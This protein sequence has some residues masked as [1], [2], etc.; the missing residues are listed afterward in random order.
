MNKLFEM[1]EIGTS[2]KSNEWYTPPYILEAVRNV[3]GPIKLDPAS[4]ELA[5][6]TV[7]AE[8]YFTKDDNGLTRPWIA[9]SVYL[10]PPYGKTEQGDGSNLRYFTQHLIE[11]YERGNVK[12]AILLIPVNTATSWFPALFAYSICFP[13]FRI[14][15]IKANGK[16]SNGVSFGTCFVY[17]G[18][19]VLKFA[20][21]FSQFGPVVTQNGVHR[22]EEQAVQPALWDLGEAS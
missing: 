14:R 20:E 18:S 3:I 5:N 12:Q 9:D 1:D 15:F 13:S 7:Q 4:C 16:P 2:G 8:R 17:F 6:Q 19:N 22:I 11:Q 10:N 21:I